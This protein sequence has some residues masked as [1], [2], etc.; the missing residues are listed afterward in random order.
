MKLKRNQKGLS[1]IEVLISLSITIT[2]TGLL[3]NFLFNF[4][5][6][7]IVSTKKSELN[8]ELRNVNLRLQ[9]EI[10]SCSKLIGVNISG[11]DT[12]YQAPAEYLNKAPFT[13]N[14]SGK[15]DSNSDRVV[16]TRPI[17]NK[18]TY[19][20]ASQIP[21][22]TN[23]NDVI[24]IEFVRNNSSIG[25]GKLLFSL[26]PA[27]SGG[28]GVD[29]NIFARSPKIIKQVLSSNIS[30]SMSDDSYSATK[31]FRFFSDSDNALDS[32]TP[33]VEDK[34]KTELIEVNLYGKKEHPT[35]TIRELLST[36]ITLR[37]YVN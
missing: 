24:I 7:Q 32:P 34:S 11:K 26:I 18:T 23:K 8:S 15:L 2:I 22:D 6:Q 3:T 5:N 25:Q 35:R 36:K 12:R 21:S 1:L 9:K 19:E 27:P 4:N 14:T 28:S 37:N 30:T 33:N 17:L 29:Y 16:L 31:P 13:P 10:E 20:K